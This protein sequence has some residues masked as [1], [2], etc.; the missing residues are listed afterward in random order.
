MMQ[1][2]SSALKPVRVLLVNLGH[3][4]RDV[5]DEIA[6]CVSRRFDTEVIISGSL[7]SEGSES[8]SKGSQY[9]ASL[10]LSHLGQFSGDDVKVLG[11]T[12][13]D[14]SFPGLNYVFGL[15]EPH[16]GVSVVSGFR[17][18]PKGHNPSIS[19]RLLQRLIK[20]SFHELGHLFGLPHC[21]QRTCVMFFSFS[22]ADTDHKSAEFCTGCTDRLQRSGWIDLSLTEETYRPGNGVKGGTNVTRS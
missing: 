3:F 2:V 4:R 18:N 10:L 19:E 21:T 7:L 6:G 5:L 15:S 9:P 20:T 8:V 13:V 22:I 12:D 14:L 1:A 11:I 17:F 16:T